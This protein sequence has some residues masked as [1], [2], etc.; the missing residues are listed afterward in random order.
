MNNEAEVAGFQFNISGVNLTG[1]AGGSAEDNGFT[2]STSGV[3][4]VLGFSFTGSTIPPS[5]G[6]LTVIS[7]D[8]MDSEICIADAILSNAA[9][10]ALDVEVVGDC[11]CGLA[12]DC[13]DECGGSATVDECG[14]CGGDGPDE[15]FD[16][17][18]NCLVDIDCEGMCGGSAQ[19]DDC[20]VCEG[21]NAD[22][23]CSDTCFGDAEEDECGICEGDGSMCTVSMAL[24]ID[25]ATG[26]MLVHM[27][28]AMDVAGFQFEISN[29]NLNGASGGTSADNSFMVS[30]GG[31]TV[32]GFSLE[33]NVIPAGD[34]VLVEL[35]YTALW[36]E[37]CMSDVVLSDPVG[38][39]IDFELGDCIALD[40]VVVD[41]CMDSDACN[42]N[43]DANSD[44]GSCTYPE[45]NYDC[46]GNCAI[47]I[48]CAGECGGDLAF[49]ECGECGGDDSTCTGCMDD[50]ALN[51]DFEATIPCDDCCQYPTDVEMGVIHVSSSGEIEIEMTN[52]N[53]VAGFQFELISTCDMAINSGYGGSAG[54]A[55]FTISTSPTGLTVLGFS[56][57][58]ST[59][60]VGS[61]TLLFL[62]ATFECES[63]SFGLENVIISDISG[64]GMSVNVYDDYEYTEG[65]QD[66]G[67]A[68]YGEEGDCL[69]N[70]YYSVG[71][72]ETGASHLIVFLDTIEGLDV[73]D[74]I[75][76]FD[77]SG[78]IETVDSGQTAEYGEV[79]VGAG[80]W[81]GIGNSEG[82]VTSVTGIMSQDLSDFNGPILNGAIDG[83]DVVIKI[84]DAS[85]GI[86]YETE[87][88]IQTGG[89]F[90][91]IFT[92]IDE[93]TL[94]GAPNIGDSCD[95][96]GDGSAD[97]G[98]VDCSLN[99]AAG[100]W[101]GD[102]FCDD[103]SGAYNF[104]CEE[105]NWDEGDCDALSNDSVNPSEFSLSQNYPNPF[106]PQT[107]IRFSVPGISDVSINI[108]DLNGKL[109]D[110]V[111]QGVYSQGTHIVVW[112]GM[113][114]NRELV[115]SG[116][117]LY[118][119]IT[120]NATLTKQLTII[121]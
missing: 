90:G 112:D 92:V 105:L 23:D 50:M 73:G 22:M 74:E 77:A 121:R 98:L 40:F 42:Y 51:Y 75:G 115:S 95:L 32:L 41:G 100:S 72:N 82:T 120:P 49:D 81:D 1:A 52:I 117:Y 76:I 68:N 44:D 39:A 104:Q 118:K 62:D 30:V 28:N 78:V 107:M 59:I 14:E 87:I 9:G 24:S 5:N 4:V 102:G 12:V 8:S 106:N 53:E 83:N 18:G 55:G 34:A 89:E 96:N 58:G 91:D 63:G 33:G 65:C 29:V 60:P 35:D 6:I 70:S 48:D 119:L 86:E 67:A 2:V 103:G 64:S 113:T 101:L 97:D 36:N 7:F 3:G 93:I 56:L 108:Y 94:S 17:D 43:S 19:L 13:A 47:E 79:L 99:C 111:A 26:N 88:T 16:C 57:T 45:D 21:G 110:I 46:D 15:N 114:L 66:E 85:E 54:D 37:A 69:Y 25:D 38:G 84:Y 31:G 11:Y 116:V 80:M 10:E 109:V 61:G 71:I 27:S 20:G